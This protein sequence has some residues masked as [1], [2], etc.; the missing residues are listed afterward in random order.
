MNDIRIT[1][2]N[3]LTRFGSTFGALNFDEK[4]FFNI[5]LSFTPYLEYKPNN[6]IHAGSPGA[7]TS[8]EILYLSRKDKIHSKSDCINGPNIKGVQKPILYS[9]V[10]DKFPGYKVLCQPKTIH[11]KKINISFLNTII[12]YLEFDNHE[13][14]NFNGET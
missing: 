10:L 3:I 12:F 6:T 9:F 4:S 5:L 1:T 13:E 7:Y 14:V 2:K 11:Y 8:D